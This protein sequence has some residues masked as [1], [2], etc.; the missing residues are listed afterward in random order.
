MGRGIVGRTLVLFIMNAVCFYKN[1]FLFSKKNSLYRCFRHTKV[2]YIEIEMHSNRRWEY[3]QETSDP[4]Q[5]DKTAAELGT[6]NGRTPP[7]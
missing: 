6:R 3:A 1:H 5:V 4:Q 7:S 2:R